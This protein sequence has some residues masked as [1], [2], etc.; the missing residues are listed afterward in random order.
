[1]YLGR[2]QLGATVGLELYCHDSNNQMVVPD[3]PPQ[4]KTFSGTT[5]VEAKLMPVEDRYIVNGVFRLPLFLGRLYAVGQY[6]VVYYYHVTGSSYY[7]IHTDNFEVI[8]GGDV[9]GAG[10]SSYFYERP[11]AD[12]VVQ[13]LESGSIIKGRNPTI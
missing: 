10:I 4:L 5:L 3:S 11:E 8:P 9:R 1:M 2:Y 13:G 7:G 6:S 12:Y